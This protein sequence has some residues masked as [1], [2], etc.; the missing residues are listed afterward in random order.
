MSVWRK[1]KEMLDNFPEKTVPMDG[2][3]LKID[4]VKKMSP[5]PIYLTE[6]AKDICPWLF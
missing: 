5:M 3:P 2:L 6:K 1:L 4:T